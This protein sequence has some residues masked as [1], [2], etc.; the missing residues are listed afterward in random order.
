MAI[1][2]TEFP[3]V[4]TVDYDTLRP[5]IRSGDILLCS[6]SAV[7]SRLIQQVTGSVW[8]HVAFVIRLDSL[9]RVMVLESVESAGVRTIPLSHYVR[10]YTPDGKG[11]PGRLLLARHRRV[12]ELTPRVLNQMS[13]FSVDRFGSP[14]DRQE[15]LRIVARIV[16]QPLG[17]DDEMVRRNR[18]YICSEYAWECYAAIG[19]EIESDPRGFV[20]PKDFARCPEIEAVAEIRVEG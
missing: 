5:E 18:E 17:L 12:Q 6:G 4:E 10:R 16:Q 13:R 9:E 11:Y 7:I 14:Y 20:A 2:V 1:A 3:G 8:S 19:I 15:M